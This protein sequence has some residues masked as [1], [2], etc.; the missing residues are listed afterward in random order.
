MKIVKT[1]NETVVYPWIGENEE[2]HDDDFDIVID[3]PP[4]FLVD[5]RMVDDDEMQALIE[6]LE[7]ALEI[8]RARKTMFNIDDKI[9]VLESA[10][11]GSKEHDD[12]EAR[13]KTGLITGRLWDDF[14]AGWV[15][16]YEVLLEN[17]ITHFLTEDEMMPVGKNHDRSK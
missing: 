15:G 10:H 7:K 6:G 14:G 3:N 1:E 13:G 12:V 5:G 11:E 2:I 17:G 8:M 9:L 16:C 4:Y